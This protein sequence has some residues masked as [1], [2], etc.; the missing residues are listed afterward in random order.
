MQAL[1]SVGV[2]EDVLAVAIAEA[3]DMSDHGPSS[4]AVSEALP[5]LEPPFWIRERQQKPLVQK[6]GK[7]W[8]NALAVMDC[9]LLRIVGV[10]MSGIGADK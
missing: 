5:R 6:R 10:S 8:G 9:H 2:N 1:A 3:E 4:T 7:V